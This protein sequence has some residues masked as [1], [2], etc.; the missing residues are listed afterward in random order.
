MNYLNKD[1]SKR[2]R[3][4]EIREICEKRYNKIIDEYNK[5]YVFIGDEESAM[6]KEK[7]TNIPSF[8]KVVPTECSS[9]ISSGRNSAEGKQKD[10]QDTDRFILYVV[11][12]IFLFLAFLIMFY[13]DKLI[14]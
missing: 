5:L 3:F 14:K 11:I 9:S 12:A 6:I 8:K 10:T 13:F 1:E 2:I 4:N 7:E